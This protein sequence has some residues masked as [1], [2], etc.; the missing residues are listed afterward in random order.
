MILLSR[1]SLKSA[2]MA[3]TAMLLF[4]PTIAH[5]RVGVTSAT[6]GDPL[7]KPPTES[8]RVLRIGIDVQSNELITTNSRDRAHL[9]FLDGTSLTVGPNARLVI[10][11]F[12]FDPASKTGDL[13]INASKGVLRLVGGKISKSNSIVITTP[14][15]TIG[16]RGGIALITVEPDATT[17][18]YI[19]GTKMEVSANGVTRTITRPGSRVTTAL[20]TVPSLPQLLPPGSL[21]GALDQLEGTAQTSG[22]SASRNADGAA[23]SSG[24]SANNSSRP[25]ALVAPDRFGSG[26]GPNN[27]N[28]TNIISNALTDANNERQVQQLLISSSQPVPQSP[29]LPPVV[30]P[31]P[32]VVQP[33]PPVVQPVP[34]VVQP[35]PPVVQPVP[36]VVQPVPPVVQPVPPVVQPVP[37]VVQ[38]PPPPPTQ[39]IVT[40]GRLIQDPVYSSV[41]TSNLATVVNPSNFAL[42]AP[43][44]T[45]KG[46]SATITVVDGRSISVP[47]QPGIGIYGV[48][49]TDPSLGTLNGQGVVSARGDYFAFVFVDASNRRLGV[50]GGTPTTMEQFPKA[51]IAT[52]TIVNASTGGLPF[53]S[54]A[55]GTDPHLKGAAQQ[56]PLY[57]VFSPDAAPQVGDNFGRGGARASSM[58]ATISVSGSGASQKSY[59]GV[60]IGEYFRDYSNNTMFS[61]GNLTGTYRLGATESTGRLTSSISTFDTGASN[62]IYGI[63][64]D[65]IVLTSDLARSFLTVGQDGRV[66]EA[67]TTRTPSAS[68]DV[69]PTGDLVD[70]YT[71][72]GATR[73]DT[74]VGVGVTRTSGVQN[75][76][77]G[78]LV[79]DVGRRTT[80]HLGGE[81]QPTDLVL[82]KNAATN[83]I[84]AT[85]VVPGWANGVG[86]ATFRLGNAASGHYPYSTFVDDQIFAIRDRSTAQ[87]SSTT[88]VTVGAQTSTGTAV[89]S[90]TVMLSYNAAPTRDF[91][92]SAGVVP[93][94]CEFLT[95]GWWTGQVTYSPD[96]VYNPG[97]RDRLNLATFVTGTPTSVG[98]LNSL[99]MQN[100]TATY[101]GHMVGN[102]LNNGAAYIAPGT[103]SSVWSFGQRNGITTATFDGATYGGGRT[104]NTFMVG[105]GPAFTAPTLPAAGAGKTMTTQGAFFSS[106]S[107]PAKYQAGRFTI[108]GT[109]YMAGG[110]FAAQ[111]P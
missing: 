43:V 80:R 101:T 73:V 20:G 83:E 38:E 67:T 78:G 86:S 91:F 98:A 29:T 35:V 97:G 61:S 8:E 4:D 32:P 47:W 13:A 77:V 94:V 34:P 42:L 41:N 10:D 2:L 31:V 9:V 89:S 48:S 37:P 39:V 111:K 11:R 81:T 51:G 50:V 65:R 84:L 26:P 55:V 27:R 110:T 28:P 36:P 52:H 66:T 1:F 7:G 6:D 44:G 68:L 19:F 18:N 57:S 79:E 106:P 103:Y 108:N 45:E 63:N 105:N 17:A 74:P 3:T 5:A 15:N 96:S 99:N 109:N 53:A 60:F 102:V 59:M 16:I 56:S 95:W 76:Y 75:G 85:I 92:Q 25:L 64:A 69:R 82:T 12:V 90:Q 49:V 40:R 72:N 33:V 58:Q 88:S 71:V 70:Y 93:C 46:G 22:P 14:S 104:P 30:Q 24:F 87:V 54:N 62:S 100:A 107:D 21:T 23:V